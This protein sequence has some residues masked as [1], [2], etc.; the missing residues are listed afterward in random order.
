MPQKNYKGLSDIPVI[1][2][3]ATP[4]TQDPAANYMFKVDNRNI[5]ARCEISSK[6]TIKTPERRHLR[7]YGVF[8]VNFEHISHLILV[9]L[10]LI[11]NM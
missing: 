1:S 7:R 10:L 5:R 8:I 11:L 3:E 2:L 6:L 9:F 4:W